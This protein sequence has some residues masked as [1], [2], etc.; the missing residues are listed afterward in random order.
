MKENGKW[1]ELDR[2]AGT[3]GSLTAGGAK[4]SASGFVGKSSPKSIEIGFGKN[5]KSEESGVIGFKLDTS[6]M[7]KPI[8]EYLRA[9]GWKKA[10]FFS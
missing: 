8:R 3:S 7:K 5:R 9:C 2:M 6:L 10:G 1:K 4:L